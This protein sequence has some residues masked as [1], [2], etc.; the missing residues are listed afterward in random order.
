LAAGDGS[1]VTIDSNVAVYAF[2]D[3]GP[4]SLIARETITRTNFVSVQVLNE[5]AAVARRKQGRAWN[6]ILAK[7]DDLT[8]V[9]GEVVALGKAST[10][11]A[12]RLA[13]RYG[14]SYYDSLLIASALLR[15]AGTIYSE[16]M[17]HGL[18]FDDRLTIVNPFR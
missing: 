17:Q 15:G 8:T 12:V 5:F 7:I 9:V 13:D 14:L 16:D 1:L 11:E 3:A 2:S 18:V 10:F 4:K 6:E